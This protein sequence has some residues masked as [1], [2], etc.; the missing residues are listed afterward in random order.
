L[1][2][3]HTPAFEN[4][5]ADSLSRMMLIQNALITDKQKQKWNKIDKKICKF[6]TLSTEKQSSELCCFVTELHQK[7]G[8][9]SAQCIY[10]LFSELQIHVTRDKIS[11]ILVNCQPCQLNK[12][13]TSKRIDSFGE[14]RSTAP[15]DIISTDIWGRYQIINKKGEYKTFYII[16][17]TDLCTRYTESC[18]FKKIKSKDVV[19][20]FKR[21]WI[22]KHGPPKSIICDRGRQFTSIRFKKICKNNSI[23]LRFTTPNNPCGNSKVER[24]HRTINEIMRIYKNN[25]NRKTIKNLIFR[26][27]NLLPNR[28]IEAIP[29]TLFKGT[30]PWN[31]SKNE[32]STAEMLQNANECSD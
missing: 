28:A 15:N 11:S 17:F 7:L 14:L 13:V 9:P 2:I 12:H 19:K 22:D 1:K 20:A 29:Y 5:V 6:A 25:T 8:H 21:S 31:H 23:K 3:T 18:I 30:T 32:K 24:I 10:K 27:L 4:S 16:Y 26:R